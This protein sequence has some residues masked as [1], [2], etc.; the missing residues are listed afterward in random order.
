MMENNA[1]WCVCDVCMCVCI[2]SYHRIISERDV[3]ELSAYMMENNA[4]WCVYVM[5]VCNV[6]RCMCVCIISYH[7]IISER[8]VVEELTQ[9]EDQH[10]IGGINTDDLVDD[11]FVAQLSFVGPLGEKKN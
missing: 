7:R 6:C 1:N 4:Y 5:C 9:K 10:S 11:R 2:I 8:D 3:V